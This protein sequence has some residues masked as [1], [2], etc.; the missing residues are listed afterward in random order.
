[1]TKNSYQFE[2]FKINVKL[3]LAALWTAVLFCYVY[4]DF[5]TLFVPGR[6]ENLIQGNSGSGATTP[7]K[8]LLYAVLM[9]LPPL[10]VFLS[11]A[12]KPKV[13]RLLNLLL[14]IFFTAIMV[15][16]TANSLDRW[17]LFYTYLGVVEIIITLLIVVHAWRWPKQH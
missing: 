8:L 16:I 7:V 9:S 14:G 15:L 5:F 1:M 6:I 17:M 11:L 2:D 3:K 10:M 12:L 4:G 13:N